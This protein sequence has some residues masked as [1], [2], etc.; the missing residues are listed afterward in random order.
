MLRRFLKNRRGRAWRALR[1]GF[2]A[3]VILAAISALGFLSAAIAAQRDFKPVTEPLSP[4]LN[5]IIEG[6]EKYRRAEDGTYLTFTEWYLVFNPQE[7]AAFIA[8]ERPSRFPYFRGIA[9]IWSGYSQTYGIVRRHYPFNAGQNLMVVVIATS[10]TVEFGLKGAYEKSVGRLFEWTAG[11]SRTPEDEFAA[12]VA[13]DYGNFIPTRPW[14]EF[15]FAHKFRELWTSTDLFGPRFLRKTERKIFLSFEYGAKALYAGLIRL[16]SHAVYGVADTEVYASGHA[17]G[18][19]ALDKPGV[20]RVRELGPGHWIF[21]VPHYQ[22]FTDTVP[23][24]A[25]A[26]VQFDEIA[27]NDEIMLTLVTP[28]DW[29]YHLSA[30]RPLFA[31]TLLAD[32]KSK[33]IAVQVPVKALSAVLGE[34]ETKGLRLEHLFDY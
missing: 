5:R 9:Q 26:G 3:G 32:S 34:I 16:A 2:L 6:T 14:F 1:L 8:K 29:T 20:R 12:Q 15:P 23:L 21:T 28:A 11:G 33:R 7:Y 30:G 19:L 24:L 22:G 27:G 18:D 31:T 4:E 17:V 25:R 10:S 13:R